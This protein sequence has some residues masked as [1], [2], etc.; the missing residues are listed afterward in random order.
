MD[1]NVKTERR[2]P[3]WNKGKPLGQ[4]LPPEAE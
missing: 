4:K 1:T 3:P 2:A